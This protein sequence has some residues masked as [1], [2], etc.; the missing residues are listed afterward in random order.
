MALNSM[1][2]NSLW[3]LWDIM[4]KEC[5]TIMKGLWRSW[6]NWSFLW[7]NLTML[8]IGKKWGGIDGLYSIM[9]LFSDKVDDK[10]QDSR[11][12]AS[13]LSLRRIAC[14]PQKAEK[15]L[16]LN[17]TSHTF[18]LAIHSPPSVPHDEYLLLEST[19]SRNGRNWHYPL[20]WLFRLLGLPWS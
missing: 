2:T 14:V 4:Q 8:S 18:L 9:Q 15:V 12:W 16:L 3:R 1:Y 7:P 10:I 11:F 5:L 20:K 19:Y 13:G 17:E 6:Q